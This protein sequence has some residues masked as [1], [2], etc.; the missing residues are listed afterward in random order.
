MTLTSTHNF[1][2]IC[3]KF[4]E[5]VLGQASA[6]SVATVSGI[7]KQKS[8]VVSSTAIK[9]PI[10]D[11]RRMTADYYFAEIKK[12]FEAQGHQDSAHLYLLGTVLDGVHKRWYE[13]NITE[14]STWDFC[15]L[16][17]KTE[18]DTRFDRSE[19]VKLLEG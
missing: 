18:F 4:A 1:G 8:V 17:Y 16:S 15:L 6:A 3:D 7:N 13:N 5:T 2:K 10:Y 19:R 12:Y 14:T 11:K 9:T